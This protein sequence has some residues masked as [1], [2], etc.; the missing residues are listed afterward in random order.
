MPGQFKFADA[1]GEG[2]ECP[3]S[4]VCEKILK[5]RVA[6]GNDLSDHYF[7]AADKKHDASYLRSDGAPPITKF[8]KLHKL[9]R[10]RVYRWVKYWDE[11]HLP[12][13]QAGIDK[14]HDDGRGRPSKCQSNDLLEHY[15]DFIEKCAED[16]DASAEQVSKDVFA[17]VIK[18]RSKNAELQ[19]WHLLLVT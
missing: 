7:T 6:K 9:S 3:P 4:P 14:F 19:T 10:S 1:L 16:Q 5:L 13:G 18:N 17:T 2:Y 11:L 8:A 15:V 12:G